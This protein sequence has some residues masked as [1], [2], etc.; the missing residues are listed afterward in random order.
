[1]RLLHRL[2]LALS[3]AA[4]ILFSRAWWNGI[5]PL[6]DD[7]SSH[8]VAMSRVAE[9]L[10]TGAGWWAPDFNLG[11]PIGL[12][13]QPL[14]HF[15][16]G[17]VT[18][19]LGGGTAAI[20][21]YKAIS[22]ALVALSPWCVALGA[23]RMGMTPTGATVSGMVSIL[24][25]SSLEFGLTVHSSLVLALHSQAWAVLWLPLALGELARALDG[26]RRSVPTAIVTWA[27]LFLS[28]FFYGV[29]LVGVVFAWVLCRPSDLLRRLGRAVGIGLATLATLSFWLVP[30]VTSLPAMGGWPFGSS[31]RVEGYGWAGFFGPLWQGALLDGEEGIEILTLLAGV[32]LS[33][34]LVRAIR[35]MVAR[36]VLVTVVLGALFTVGRAGLGWAADLFFWNRS[37]QMFR[38]LGLFHL[39]AIWLV[40]WT[41][42][43]IW[44]AGCAWGRASRIASPT[45][46]LLNAGRQFGGGFRPLVC[47]LV[48]GV[49]L[50]GLLALPAVRGWG[51]L[52]RSFRTVEDAGLELSEYL[53]LVEAIREQTREHGSGRIFV[54]PRSGLFGH[55]HSALLALW[56]ASHTGQSYGVG[57]HDSLNFYYLEFFHPELD[58]NPTFVDLYGFQYIAADPEIDF[59]A[60]DAE[61]VYS[62][63]RYA[64]WRVSHRQSVCAPIDTLPA[65]EGY[66][67][68]ARGSVLRWLRGNGPEQGVHPLLS[69]PTGLAFGGVTEAPVEVEGRTTVQVPAGEVGQLELSQGGADWCGCRV[70][71]NRRGALLFRVSYHPFWRVTVDGR[72]APLSYA[73]P[74]FAAVELE[75]GHHD[76][77]LTYRSCRAQFWLVLAA[78]LPALVAWLT[79]GPARRKNRRR[80]QAA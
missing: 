35:S 7:S 28:H 39:G 3:S 72:P 67:R 65:E 40:G 43:E 70:V 66:P 63:P 15:V 42:G 78:P 49:A 38:Y 16:G 53:G 74:A 46:G 58:R 23:R 22:I 17:V 62:S 30:L 56:S 10:Q 36:Q 76:V 37:V 77:R 80:S 54:H 52:K 2:A 5:P 50:V 44:Q 18:L 47:Q 1:M 25:I 27:L 32:G 8:I 51:E 33:L 68:N 12:Y 19:L 20:V 29:A 73:F 59:S 69:I 45:D 61:R 41:F 9:I 60:V 24:I 64:L 71:M 13:Y 57:L 4:V 55:F 48:L 21:A 14:P 34:C 79:S 6:G 75:E 26:D 31:T 11:F